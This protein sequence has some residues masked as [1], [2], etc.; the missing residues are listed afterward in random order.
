MRITIRYRKL[1]LQRYDIMLG[2]NGMILFIIGVIRHV[3]LVIALVAGMVQV[4][5][6]RGRA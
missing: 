6:G 4:I 1:L 5:Q 3:L 2:Y